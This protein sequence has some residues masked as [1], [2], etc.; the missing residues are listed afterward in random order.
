MNVY[1]IIEKK[2]KN[3]NCYDS[4]IKPIKIQIDN[5]TQTEYKNTNNKK[6]QTNIKTKEM[7]TQ[8]DVIIFSN[9]DFIKNIITNNFKY[10]SFCTIGILFIFYVI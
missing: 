3:I 4:D 10:I 9:Y 1:T 2:Q 7:A 5:T 8:T 6:L